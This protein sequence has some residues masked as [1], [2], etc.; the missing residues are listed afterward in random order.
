MA[1]DLI[2]DLKNGIC[3]VTY[4]S[5]NSNKE[6]EFEATLMPEH[7]YNNT[8]LNQREDTDKILMYNCTFEKWEDIDKETIL[9]WIKL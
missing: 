3:L 7:I 1:K 6:K 9:G 8:S 2:E 5:L 4:R